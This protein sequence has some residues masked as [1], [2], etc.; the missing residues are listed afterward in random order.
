M[1]IFIPSKNHQKRHDTKLTETSHCM[2]SSLSFVKGQKKKVQD[3]Y[4]KRFFIKNI[5]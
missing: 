1:L 2:Q 5:F 4:G 3:T